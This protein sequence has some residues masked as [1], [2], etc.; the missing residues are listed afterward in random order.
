M[1]TLVNDI[2]FKI[3][4][5]QWNVSYAWI[6]KQ[7]SFL[8]NILSLSLS[9]SI[10]VCVLV[11]TYNQLDYIIWYKSRYFSPLYRL[12]LLGVC[13]MASETQGQRDNHV[14]ATLEEL[15]R[16]LSEQSKTLSD[17]RL[18]NERLLGTTKRYSTCLEE[19]RS[20]LMVVS[21]WQ[22]GKMVDSR[23]LVSDSGLALSSTKE[24]QVTNPPS[25][26][27]F[28]HSRWTIIHPNPSATEIGDITI[29]VR[30]ILN[31]LMVQIYLIG[32]FRREHY[33]EVDE[34]P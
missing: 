17:H 6:L 27:L 18:A 1:I 23:I 8:L 2:F 19:I 26:I 30:L 13:T 29:S 24:K 5:R 3:V 33:F 7:N 31:D 21:A 28:P 22:T 16:D 4:R 20:M 32:F 14:Y 25:T 15:G 10:F 12:R 11:P 34:T 9:L